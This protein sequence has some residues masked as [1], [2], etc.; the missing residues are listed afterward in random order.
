MTTNSQPVSTTP[1]SPSRRRRSSTTGKKSNPVNAAKM[2]MIGTLGAALIA[3]LPAILN[4][5]NP[6]DGKAPATPIT[7]IQS[8][9]RGSVDT[10][11]I[12][13]SGTKVTVSGSAEPRVDAVGVMISPPAAGKPIWT[14]ATNVSDGKWSLVVTADQKLPSPVEIKAFYKERTVSAEPVTKAS[15]V[16]LQAGST[17]STPPPPAPAQVNGCASQTG[18]GC[19]T[20]PGWGPPSIYRTGS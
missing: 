3:A 16:I 6:H 17:T 20:G 10:V 2:T 5:V 1:Q 12:S 8:S 7:E 11:T 18:D 14:G 13:D 4:A 19:F 9:D 15:Y